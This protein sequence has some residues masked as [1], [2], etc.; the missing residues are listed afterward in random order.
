MPIRISFADETL[1]GGLADDSAD[2]YVATGHIRTAL[3]YPDGAVVVFHDGT[4]TAGPWIKVCRA[5]P[6][7]M[8][9]VFSRQELDLL[10]ETGGVAATA[11]L[12]NTQLVD[13]VIV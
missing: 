1:G 4:V 7:P 9:R 2:H 5:Y 13:W 6:Q 3:R 10:V 8:R 12:A 11:R